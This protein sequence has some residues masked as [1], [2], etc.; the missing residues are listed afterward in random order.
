MQSLTVGVLA[1]PGLPEK[2]A[3]RVAEDLPRVDD[4]EPLLCEVGAADAAALVSLP[5]LGADHF[6]R[7]ACRLLAALAGALGS[8]FDSDE[9]IREATYSRRE[10]QRRRLADT[11]DD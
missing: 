3:R 11:Y 7:K 5:G 6:S 9:A 4:G 1:D 8:N 2:V 10:H